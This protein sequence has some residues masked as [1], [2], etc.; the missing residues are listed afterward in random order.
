MGDRKDGI[1][2]RLHDKAAL[3]ELQVGSCRRSGTES[4]EHF[5]LKQFKQLGLRGLSLQQQRYYFPLSH[6]YLTH[7]H[8]HQRCK[9]GSYLPNSDQVACWRARKAVTFWNKLVLIAENIA[10]E[11]IPL[12]SYIYGS[13]FGTNKGYNSTLKWILYNLKWLLIK[14]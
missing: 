5:Q 14:P 3:P 2:Q 13:L 10:E 4:L 7:R 11:Q 1:F 8:S 12:E 9:H 6:F